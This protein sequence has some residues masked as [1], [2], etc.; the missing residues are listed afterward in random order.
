[1]P[2]FLVLVH[3]L[4]GEAFAWWTAVSLRFGGRL[5]TWDEFLSEF[6]KR[7]YTRFHKNGQ[8]QTFYR[9]EQ[10]TRSVIEFEKELRELSHFAPKEDRAPSQLARCFQDGLSTHIKT[11]IGTT[12]VLN[13]QELI[14]TSNDAEKMIL[15]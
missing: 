10:G 4:E 9:V 1:M 2:C 6:N 15:K 12:P 14:V 7:F 13:F 11:I 8:R 3:L 5:P